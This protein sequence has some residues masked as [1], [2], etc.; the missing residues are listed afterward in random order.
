VVGSA[1]YAE[2]LG[3]MRPFAVSRLAAAD[4][5]NGGGRRAG[6]DFAGRSG[7]SKEKE[8]HIFAGYDDLRMLSNGAKESPRRHR[9]PYPRGPLVTIVTS[10]CHGRR[11][12]LWGEPAAGV[13]GP[14]GVELADLNAVRPPRRPEEGFLG[15][16]SLPDCVL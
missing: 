12:V 10:G 1:G 6:A 9:Y 13:R 11:I 8:L 5:A 2:N 16:P 15:K 3:Q 14:N 7:E 4:G